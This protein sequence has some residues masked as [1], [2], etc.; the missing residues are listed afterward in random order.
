MKHIGKLAV[1]GA[2][3]AASAPFAS[4]TPFTG[5]NITVNG[6]TATDTGSTGSTFNLASVGATTVS[7][8]GAPSLGT[9]TVNPVLYTFSA[10]GGA[11]T[12]SGANIGTNPGIS[13]GV[14]LFTAT[15]GSA[16]VYF[17]GTSYALFSPD[18]NGDY[19]FNIY[20]YFQD[21][22]SVTPTFGVD[23]IQFNAGNSTNPAVGVTES[24]SITPTPEPSSL[25][26]LGTGLVG[27]AGAFLR[28]RVTA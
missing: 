9:Y 16:P 25:M 27:A 5:S 3:L 24:F 23:N 22:S 26:L 17:Y 10:S 12:A 13:G 2:V 21:G 28:K 20:G 15:N 7:L 18:G 19:Q 4:A 6:T 1:L 14:E 8:G 11:I